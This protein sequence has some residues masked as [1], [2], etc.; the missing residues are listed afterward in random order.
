MDRGPF[1]AGGTPPGASEPLTRTRAVQSAS[2]PS[3]A[4]ERRT[5]TPEP[6]GCGVRGSLTLDGACRT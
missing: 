5:Q 1:E 6:A 2:G 4:S 3:D